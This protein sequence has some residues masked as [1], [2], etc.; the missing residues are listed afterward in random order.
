LTGT[1]PECSSQNKTRT[2][3]LVSRTGRDFDWDKI[4]F[5]L[6]C[7]LNWNKNT[8]HSGQN[9]IELRTWYNHFEISKALFQ[10]NQRIHPFGNMKPGKFGSHRSRFKQYQWLHSF[11]SRQF[12][13]FEISWPFFQTNQR[14]HPLWNIGNMENL[15]TLDLSSNNVHGSVPTMMCMAFSWTHSTSCRA[16]V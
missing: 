14:I 3:Q 12:N 15:K 10:L 5:G 6:F 1:E 7:F 11:Q 9:R 2:F 16:F 4:Y 13:Q 8:G